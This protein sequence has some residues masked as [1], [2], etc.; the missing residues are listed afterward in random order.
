MGAM[1]RTVESLLLFQGGQR[2]ARRNAWDAV[3]DDRRRARQRAEA[4]DILERLA[5]DKPNRM[6]SL[7]G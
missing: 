4:T 3:C 6:G 7:G 2:T 1:L 5:A